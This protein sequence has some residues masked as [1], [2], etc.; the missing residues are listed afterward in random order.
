MFDPGQYKFVFVQLEKLE[1]GDN[2]YLHYNG[3]RYTYTVTE[4]EVILPNEVAKVIKQTDKP[5]AS[6]I[7]CVPVGTALKRLVVTAEQISPDP[8]RASAADT[9]QPADASTD[10]P[11]NSPTFFERLFGN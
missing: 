1:K 5:L 10:L 9:T 7:T 2:F 4:I 8:T 3:I 6:L 11:G